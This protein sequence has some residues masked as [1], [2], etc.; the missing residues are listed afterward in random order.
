VR[1]LFLAEVSAITVIGG[2]ERVLQEQ[3]LGLSR[4][5]HDVVAVVRAPL[6]DARPRVTLGAVQEHRYP[7]SR[8]H[9]LRFV[10]DSINGAVAKMD[11]AGRDPW[12]AAVVQQSLAGLGPILR[13]RRAARGWIYVCHSLAHEEYLSRTGAEPD[14]AGRW[15]RI[16]NARMRFWC[17]RLV[18]RRCARIVVLS[19]FMKQRVMT[20][21]GIAAGAIRVIPGGVDVGRFRPADDPQALRQR[22]KLPLDRVILFTLRNLVPRMGLDTLL[23]ALA[24]LGEERQD[25]LLL[26]G[27]EGPLRPSLQRRIE[28]L[29]LTAGVQLLGFVGEEELPQYYQAADLVVMPTR[30][31]EGFGLVTVEAL[32]CGTPVLGTP[33]GAIP[34]VL[35]RLDPRLVAEGYEAP[36]LAAALRRTLA[37]FRDQPGEQDRLSR[38]ARELV[39]AH[40]QWDRHVEQLEAAVRDAGR[41]TGA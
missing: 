23:E 10:L 27:G 15:R 41:G 20:T 19:D 4:R 31:L 2:A 32:A 21:H 9:A 1:L 28:A 33:V 11:D 39:L 17:E 25:L 29:N 5:G 3:A 36:A 24:T 8:A 30:E 40:Y 12:D 6:G 16:V 14:P 26:I 18:L 38:L 13:R 34:E 35:A 7:V 37:R 22:L